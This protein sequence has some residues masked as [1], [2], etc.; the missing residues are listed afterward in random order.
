M[1]LTLRNGSRHTFT[2]RPDFTGARTLEK[3]IQ[4]DGAAN[5][6][7]VLQALDSLH[8]EDAEERKMNAA[9]LSAVQPVAF[10][11]AMRELAVDFPDAIGKLVKLGAGTPHDVARATQSIVMRVT[12]QRF[13]TTPVAERLKKDTGFSCLQ[14]ALSG[15]MQ[16]APAQRDQ[17]RG[18]FNGVLKS[19][20][21][22]GLAIQRHDPT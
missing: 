13:K 9:L 16:V 18:A 6:G 22:E 10:N 3:F 1:Q 5:P 20:K 19:H 21:L 14:A 15:S 4:E 17:M 11:G 2:A 12:H 7:I 8:V